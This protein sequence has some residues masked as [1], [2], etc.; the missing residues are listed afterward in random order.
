MKVSMRPPSQTR[1]C[2]ISDRVGLAKVSECLFRNPSFVDPAV[3]H[4]TETAN[5][6]LDSRSHVF[7]RDSGPERAGGE[8]AIPL[9]DVNPRV[10]V[11]I[12][13]PS[14]AFGISGDVVA[15]ERPGVSAAGWCHRIRCL[16][17]SPTAIASCY[18]NRRK[19]SSHL[20]V[21]QI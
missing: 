12:R 5:I 4:S 17:R 21:G 18:C 6:P 16:N 7:S 13:D 15:T 9:K 1:F 8:E 10:L 19:H 3:F 11:V 14:R 20:K 2:T